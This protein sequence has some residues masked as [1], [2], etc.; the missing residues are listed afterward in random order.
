MR[1]YELMIIIDVDTDEVGVDEIVGQVASHM[2]GLGGRVDNENRWGRRRFA[3]EINHKNEGIYTVLELVT[4]GGDMAPLERTLLL[5]DG[6]VRH[7]L[8]RLPEKE[9]ARR[10]LLG[11]PADAP[12]EIETAEQQNGI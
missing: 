9:A 12:A 6:V 11:E 10:G 1:A 4:P 3:Y 2:T 8:I 7:K 5:A